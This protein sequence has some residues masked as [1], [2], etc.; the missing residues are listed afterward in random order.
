MIYHRL[1]ACITVSQHRYDFDW[2]RRS[3][4]PVFLS[5]AS[6]KCVARDS[7]EEHLVNAEVMAQEKDV[8]HW[9]HLFKKWQQDCKRLENPSVRAREE[10]FFIYVLR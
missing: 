10:I 3:F 4:F 6:T 8:F 1:F 9:A 2:N 7:A 5:S